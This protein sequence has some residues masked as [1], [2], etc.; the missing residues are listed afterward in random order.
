MSFHPVWVTARGTIGTYPSQIAM[1]F[2]FVATPVPPAASLTYQLLSGTMPSGLILNSTTGVLSGLPGIVSVDTVYNFALRATDDLGNISDR[3]F[4]ISI[5]GLALPSFI[6]PTGQILNTLDSLWTELQ[7][8]YSNPIPTNPVSIR[9]AQGALPPGLQINRLGLIRGYPEAPIIE[10]NYTEQVTSAVSISSSSVIQV[11][12]TTGFV[13]GR[14]VIFTGSTYG[15]ITAL[16]TYYIKTVIN[17]TTFTISATKDGEP[18]TLTEGTGDMTVTLPQTQLGQPT[19]QTFRF[20]L[21]LV[22]PAG[23]ALEAYSITVVNQQT[24]TSQGGPGYGANSRIPTIYNTR[25]ATFDVGTDDPTNYGYY[26]FPDNNPNQTYLPSQNAYIGKYESGEF[27]SFRILGHDFDGDVLTYQFVDLPL[28]LIGNANTGWI[29]GTPV[30]AADTISNYIFSVNVKK[31]SFTSVQSPVFNYQ[32]TVT[33]DII[34]EV[35]WLTPSD[36]GVLFNSQTSILSVNATSDVDL[37]YRIVGGELPPNLTLLSNGEIAG[38]VAYQPTDAL[39]QVGDQTV[40]NFEIEAYSPLHP[41]VNSTKSF[42]LTIKQEYDQPVD[43]LYIK[44]T[45]SLEDRNLINELL[46]NPDII[47]IAD[48]YRPEDPNFG[49]ATDI[50]YEHAFGIDASNFEEYVAAF[51][52]NHYWRNITL[53]ELKTAVAK[54]SAGEIV[55]EVVYSQIQDNLI[56]PSGKSI[57]S[58]IIWPRNIP[59]NQGPWYTSVTD[60]FSSYIGTDP[61]TGGEV[62]YT[63]L[64]PGFARVLYPNSLPNMRDRTGEVLGQQFDFRLLPD[65]MTSQQPNGTAL[66]YTPAWVLAYCK[67]GK[68]ETIKNNI[69]TMWVD[70]LGRPYTLNMINFQ[71][72]RVTVDKSITYNYDKN[73]TPPAWTGLPSATPTPNPKNSKDFHVL[74]PQRTILPNERNVSG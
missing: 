32:L 22:S 69:Q 11:L 73:L 74:F 51:E 53:G 16:I 70:A 31:S 21:E 49:K 19:I 67:P 57:S 66:G 37:S 48:I 43:T 24:P 8:E 20:T 27:F 58:S 36:L 44:C 4:S 33:N 12:S 5:T 64:T 28:G 30:I 17:S 2:R 9:V 72:D 55:Y 18:L 60:I 10:S 62:Y 23:S 14:P 68:A 25:P 63:S 59:L 52:K 3:S 65:W 54:N 34:G 45:S 46:T 15:G 47:P 26:V 71:L 1:S 61:D 41:V 29:T 6:T 38:D 50:I 7:I 40:F 35:T 39:L 56:N 13:V 42:T